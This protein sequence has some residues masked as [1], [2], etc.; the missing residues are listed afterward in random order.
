MACCTSSYPSL[1]SSAN[2]ADVSP[3][4]DLT[5]RHCSCCPGLHLGSLDCTAMLEFRGDSVPMDAIDGADLH[6]ATASPDRSR[7]GVLKESSSH[8]SFGAVKEERK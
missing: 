4:E 7:A 3:D 5:V 8:K 6:L 1:F 2:A